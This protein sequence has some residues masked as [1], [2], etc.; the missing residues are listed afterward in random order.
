MPNLV[1]PSFRSMASSPNAESNLAVITEPSSPG[2]RT[3][4]PARL[5][6]GQKPYGWAEAPK[7]LAAGRHFGAGPEAY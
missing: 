4:Y 3:G 2:A 6:E 1:N 7:E 5:I